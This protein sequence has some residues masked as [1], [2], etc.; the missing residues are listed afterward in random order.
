[1]SIS[2]SISQIKENKRLI[3]L[4]ILTLTLLAVAGIWFFL[5][6]SP[7]QIKDDINISSEE[8]VNYGDN[9]IQDNMNMQYDLQYN[10][11][12]DNNQFNNE[13]N[14]NQSEQNQPMINA[15]DSTTKDNMQNE[16][17]LNSVNS[18]ENVFL[19]SNTNTETA[20][21]TQDNIVSRLNYSIKPLDM[22]VASCYTM[23]NG[24][25]NMVNS[26][27]DSMVS[28]I[29]HLIDTNKEIVALEVSGIVDSNPYAGPSAELK[30]EG[31]ASFRAREA[32][33]IIT[34]EFSNIAV[35]EGLSMQVSNK[36]GFEVKAYYLHK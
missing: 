31:L 9:G 33:K 23:S 34:S 22:I 25:W 17:G 21:N 30:Q 14:I 32:I 10:P 13:Q 7:N 19:Q 27:E 6:Y 26:C 11:N 18:Q 16:L 2:E 36:R 28:S 15:D 20:L 5:F 12:V 35:F 8:I 29:N 3:V 1:M 24:R 4:S